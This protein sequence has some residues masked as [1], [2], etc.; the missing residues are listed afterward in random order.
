DKS[1]G[2]LTWLRS[3]KT[4]PYPYIFRTT[5]ITNR[6]SS[7]REIQLVGQLPPAPKLSKLL[8]QW[9]LVYRQ[10]ILPST[11]IKPKA[12]QVTQETNISCQVLGSRLITELNS[13]LNSGFKEWQKLRERLQQNLNENDE[14]LIVI[15]TD[16]IQVRQLPWHWWSLLVENYLK[17]E[18]VL[19]LPDY[20][21][22]GNQKKH[23]ASSVRILAI[24]GDS[25]GINIQRDRALLEQLP[26]ATVKFLVEPQRRQLTEQLW[27]ANWDILF[28]AGHSGIQTN[29]QISQLYINQ[30]DTLT[31]SDL[32]YALR[33]AVEHGLKLAIFNSCDGL[34]L[35]RDLADL[36]IPQI[37]VMREAVPDR[38][39]QE[40]LKYFLE[41]FASGISLYLAVREARERL[42]GWENRFPYASWLPVIFQNPAEVSLTWQGL[43]DHQ[44]ISSVSRSSTLTVLLTS[45]FV[46]FL[47]IGIRYLGLLQIWELQTFDRLVQLR[48]SEQ[49]DP[50][51]L[52]IA[53]TENDLQLPQQQQ[54]KGSLSDT[55]LHQLLQKLEPYKPRVI[56]LDIYRDF[57]VKQNDLA[58]RM[59]KNESLIAICKASDDS[60]NDPGVAPPPEVSLER[61]GFSDFITDPD[62]ILRRY[63]LAMDSSPSSPCTTPYAFNVQLAFRY[64][65][66]EGILPRYTPSG[67]LKLGDTIFKP[68]E[69]HT[70][71]Y[72]QV[73]PWGHQVL[74]N[75]R[76]PRSPDQIAATLTLK[77]VLEGKFDRDTIL[78][79][80]VLIGT[81][82]NS[83][84]D[85]WRTPYN[86]NEWSMQSISGVAL[87]AQ[88]VSQI[89]S[90]V[91]D[92]R[93]CLANAG[94]EQLALD[95]L[96]LLHLEN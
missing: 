45:I 40:F 73:D 69:A 42:Q 53:I 63:L 15:E 17:A 35:A 14:I 8:K 54:R 1:L 70:G 31:I 2:F 85:Y 38:I 26:G 60:I 66:T 47:V 33:T 4:L 75:Y 84:Q 24:L 20:R 44:H 13:W 62:G 87:Q 22:L 43:C 61:L 19:S 52:I 76:V 37:I 58:E 65:A 78:D 96:V 56:G 55:A 6:A 28:F 64:L 34:G 79:R 11:R 41:A 39:A 91:L 46:T 80:I 82:A 89:L 88:M 21:S 32:R 71:P 9:Q 30:A 92:N 36:H 86:R 93:S 10:I 5:R 90:A 48:P 51:L 57:P 25:T 94:V 67:Y 18:V 12:G 23:T 95:K 29:G 3:R 50:R 77:Q 16:D 83:F 7:E 68:L 59:R 27:G 72:Q 49:P 81:T 74:L